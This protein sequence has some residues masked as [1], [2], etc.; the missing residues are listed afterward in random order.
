MLLL[1]VLA[2]GATKDKFSNSLYCLL[3]I[4]QV[5]AKVINLGQ[6]ATKHFTMANTWHSLATSGYLHFIVNCNCKMVICVDNVVMLV[7]IK[8]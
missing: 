2:Y 4:N 7:T 5:D 1:R 8:D 3:L 6:G